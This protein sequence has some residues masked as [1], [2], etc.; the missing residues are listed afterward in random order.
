MQSFLIMQNVVGNTHQFQLINYINRPNCAGPWVTL[1]VFFDKL[2]TP[3]PA[4]SPSTCFFP[5]LTLLHITCYTCNMLLADL[6]FPDHIDMLSYMLLKHSLGF[7]FLISF[8]VVLLATHK[9]V[10]ASNL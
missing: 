4:P 3:P 10:G 7:S 9:G 5:L 6:L 1:I 2:K 8:P